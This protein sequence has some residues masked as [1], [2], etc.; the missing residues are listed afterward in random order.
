[1]IQNLIMH[2]TLNYKCVV[3]MQVPSSIVFKTQN[4]KIRITAALTEVSGR[5]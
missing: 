5:L 2:S 4:D 3:S 1:M